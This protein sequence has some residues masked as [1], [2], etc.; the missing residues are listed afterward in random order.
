MTALTMTSGCKSWLIAG[1]SCPM[2]RKQLPAMLGILER[3][4]EATNLGEPGNLVHGIEQVPGYEVAL[5]ESL[6]KSPSYYG[7]WMVNRILEGE[8]PDDVRAAWLDVMRKVAESETAPWSVKS[9]AQEFLRFQE[10]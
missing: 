10:G 7:V 3:F 4:P 8:L 1:H 9:T 5:A 6:E 2:T